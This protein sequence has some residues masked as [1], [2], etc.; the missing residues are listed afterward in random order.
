MSILAGD[1]PAGNANTFDDSVK[2]EKFPTDVEGVEA[3]GYIQQGTNKFPKFK[4]TQDEFHQNMTDGRRRLRWKT[5]TP[6]QKYMAGT[7]YK[8]PFYVSY[9]DE[10][11]GKVYTRKIK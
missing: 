4:V 8:I 7:K 10:K 1:E 6:V 11:S 5:D 9:T 2:D 3:D